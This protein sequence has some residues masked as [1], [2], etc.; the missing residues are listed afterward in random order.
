MGGAYDN[1]QMPGAPNIA[2]AG[3]FGTQL[4]QMLS[5]LPEQYRKGADFRYQQQQR[6]LFQGG[7]P[8]GQNGQPDYAAMLTKMIQSGGSPVAGQV[9]PEMIGVQSQSDFYKALQRLNG[10]AG[11]QP[12]TSPNVSP[13]A[14]SP[15]MLRRAAGD[16]SGGP[17]L[18]S[19]GSDN[20]GSETIRSLTAGIAGGRDVPDQVMTT[21]GKALGGIAPDTPLSPSQERIA[22]RL[23]GTNL[24]GGGNTQ[25][26]PPQ[27]NDAAST[28]GA[29][30]VSTAGRGVPPDS[31]PAPGGGA[32]PGDVP[33]SQRFNGAQPSTPIGS[34]RD[35]DRHDEL[36]SRYNELAAAP[37]ITPAQAK[38]A[39]NEGQRHSAIAKQ[40]REQLGTYNAPGTNPQIQGSLKQ[41][42][43]AGTAI[44]KRIG[45]AVEAGGDRKSVV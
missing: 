33:F 26:A 25:S 4:F 30:T 39:E 22:R 1:V 29:D 18:S 36:A 38:A 14:Q 13:V 41:Y 9:I 40:I 43:G 20:A 16:Q 5:S 44:G 8:Q 7:V 2:T 21:F 6:D 32:Q 15:D 23:I 37:R 45:E 17:S 31:F 28:G 10:G 27:T 12:N 35:A 11:A 19:T 34:L 42:E 24:R 3:Q